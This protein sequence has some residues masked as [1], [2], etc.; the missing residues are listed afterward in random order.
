MQY[1]RLLGCGSLQNFF[2]VN[3]VRFVVPNLIEIDVF[4][5]STEHRW[6]HQQSV[7]SAHTQKIGFGLSFQGPGTRET[8]HHP[9]NVFIRSNIVASQSQLSYTVAVAFGVNNTDRLKCEI[10][11]CVC[12]C[13]VCPQTRNNRS[14]N[15]NKFAWLITI[16]ERTNKQVPTACL[17]M[18]YVKWPIFPRMHLRQ[19]AFRNLKKKIQFV[20]MPFSTSIYKRWIYGR[21]RT[22]LL[23]T[24]PHTG[25]ASVQTNSQC[26]FLPFSPSRILQRNDGTS[27]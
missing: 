24:P 22:S 3:F 18:K 17:N 6:S 26:W 13:P 21:T 11:V 12:V 23:R 1:C 8:Q 27:T 20:A 19:C 5:L 16:D 25:A 15:E 10:G 2:C 7:F 14:K 4:I 9:Y